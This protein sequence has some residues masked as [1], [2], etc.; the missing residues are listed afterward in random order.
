MLNPEL[1]KMYGVETK[2]M[3]INLVKELG[4][5]LASTCYVSSMSCVDSIGNVDMPDVMLSTNKDYPMIKSRIRSFVDKNSV[6]G[7]DFWIALLDLQPG[8]GD[9]QIWV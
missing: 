8:V 2:Q 6:D 3:F 1:I 7:D 5:A 4:T 9:I